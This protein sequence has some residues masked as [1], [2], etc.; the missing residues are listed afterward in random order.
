MVVR[1]A[2]APTPFD[3]EVEASERLGLAVL[4]H[5]PDSRAVRGIAALL[6][7]LEDAEPR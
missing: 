5:A 6:E 7:R 2:C 4:D 1:A 3:E